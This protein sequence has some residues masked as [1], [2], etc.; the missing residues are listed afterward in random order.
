MAIRPRPDEGV[1]IEL[2]GIRGM[3]SPIP[4]GETGVRIR[5][6][7]ERFLVPGRRVRRP[8]VRIDL[9]WR[10]KGPDWHDTDPEVQEIG[11]GF[12]IRGRNFSAL[13]EPDAGRWRGRA[14]LLSSPY[15]FDSLLRVAW[16]RI[17]LD[18][19]GMLLH[20][21]G[22][23]SGGRGFSF[24]GKSGSGKTTLVRKAPL[25]DVLSD[26]IIILRKTSRGFSIH[27]T[28][29]FGEVGKGG[30]PVRAPLAGLYFL[31]KGAP[32]LRPLPPARALSRLLGTVLF[33][34]REAAPSARLLA[35]AHDLVRAVPPAVLSSG[36][37]EKYDR[38]LK[39]LH[40]R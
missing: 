13:L 9:D 25:R 35:L 19:G 30:R 17:L 34:S 16:S 33:F 6:R 15:A 18:R 31:E 27:G 26:E 2:A 11:G 5:D 4:E 39:R 7:Y 12:R 22:T 23:I 14:S 29:F 28:P 36:L 40:G 1:W 8:D 3:F 38:I 21:A 10:A 20:S 37:R 32:A 24:A